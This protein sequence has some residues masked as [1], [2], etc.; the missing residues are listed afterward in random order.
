MDEEIETITLCD[1]ENE[2]MQFDILDSFDFEDQSY[3]VVIPDFSAEDDADDAEEAAGDSQAA[4]AEELIAVEASGAEDATG[5][6]AG[7]GANDADADEEEPEEATE[8]VILR[9]VKN[10]DEEYFETIDDDA[11]L[12]RLF[13]LFQERHDGEYEFV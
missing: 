7:D 1:D 13:A 5:A 12:D 3:V 4:G 11:L 6:S 9:S 10:G 8:V 2:T